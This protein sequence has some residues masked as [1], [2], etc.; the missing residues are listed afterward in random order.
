MPDSFM[1]DEGGL[2]RLADLQEA[3]LSDRER[4][5]QDIGLL[6][7]RFRISRSEIEALL[8]DD[9][10]APKQPVTFKAYSPIFND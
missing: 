9:V 3:E 10:V 8:A 2:K 1:L 7:K 5:L 4:A 6:A